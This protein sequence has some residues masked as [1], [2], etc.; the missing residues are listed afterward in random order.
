MTSALSRAA[1]RACALARAWGGGKNDDRRGSRGLENAVV[2]GAFASFVADMAGGV[3]WHTSEGDEDA[4]GPS[5]RAMLVE[6]LPMAE[7]AAQEEVHYDTAP[8][9]PDHMGRFRAPRIHAQVLGAFKRRIQIV[10]EASPNTFR[11]VPAPPRGRYGRSAPDSC[12]HEP[13]EHRA[14]TSL[15]ERGAHTQSGT[16]GVGRSAGRG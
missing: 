12:G 8:Q 6:R 11:G 2:A 10:G 7:V 13:R 16:R 15:G 14:Q 3:S 1:R 5:A 4:E 9:G